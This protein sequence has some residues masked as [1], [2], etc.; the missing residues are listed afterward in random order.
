MSFL[1]SFYQKYN[2]TLFGVLIVFLFVIDV[3]YL[4]IY[5]DTFVSP[6]VS[7]LSGTLMCIFAVF[8]FDRQKV[9][10]FTLEKHDISIL[11]VLALIVPMI[12]GIHINSD[13]LGDIIQQYAVDHKYSDILPALQEIYIKRFLNG[14]NVYEVY[15]KFG[16]PLYPNY[17]PLQWLP[18]VIAHFLGIDYRWLAFGIF[19]FALLIWNIRLLR[20]PISALEIFIKSALPFGVLYLLIIHRKMSFATSVELTIVGFYL[21]CAYTLFKKSNITRSVGILLPL[22]SRFSF[23]FWLA[24]YA[25]ATFITDRKNALQIIKWTTLG[26]VLI[27]LLPFFIREPNA[28]FDGLNYY[29]KASYFEWHTRHWQK[30]GAYPYHLNNGVS[31]SVY[32]YEYVDGEVE[33]KLGM[34]QL[35]H[36]IMAFVA[37]LIVGLFYW[38]RKDKSDLRLIALVGLKFC[39]TWFY[40]FLYL[41]FFYLYF[42]PIFLSMIILYELNIFQIQKSD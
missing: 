6:M 2:Q 30:E 37:A 15:E 23:L 8:A 40:A 14:E 25:V 20:K 36:K 4:T 35:F 22:L 32:F 3:L 19:I 1:K 16:N 21:I 28:F 12:I 5:R 7:F 11:R 18:Y 39:I 31:F 42:L 24:F 38:W 34:A 17:L 10:D 26:V 29:D 9:E 33:D 27:Y 13:M 41:P